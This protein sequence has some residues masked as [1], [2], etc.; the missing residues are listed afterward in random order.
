[1][2]L[3]GTL[4][5]AETLKLVSRGSARATLVALVVVGAL[6]PAWLW[7]LT[8]AGVQVNGGDL[9]QAID[10]CAANGVRWSMVVRGFYVGQALWVLL[11]AQSMAGEIQA[12]TLR[13]ELIRPVPRQL[14]LLAKWMAL[15]SWCLVSMVT[16]VA[17]GSVVAVVLLPG[18][19][20]A[21]WGQVMSGAAGAWVAEVGFLA[22]ALAVSV[23][24]RSVGG[25]I[26]ATL[27]FL[28]AE[29]M[30]SM[31]LW[32]LRTVVEGLPPDVA[33]TLPGW[34]TTLMNASPVLPSNAWSAWRELLDGATP[35]TWQA[36]V[37]LVGWTVLSAVVAE[38]VFARTD[39]P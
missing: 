26:V 30:T 7:F 36:W 5:W 3:L 32:M 35:L 39:V 12:H 27:L 21:T 16:A 28:M 31:G 24:T 15:S 17:V 1:M 33:P 20:H 10:V 19:G 25:G 14:V 38:R 18:G 4:W 6:G 13:D 37:A 8:H 9:G 2:S 29:R 23:L 11:A 34:L 22:F